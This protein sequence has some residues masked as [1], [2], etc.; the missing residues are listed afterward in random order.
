MK[1]A[2]QTT[3]KIPDYALSYLINDDESG[4]NEEDIQTIDQWINKLEEG[5]TQTIL[6]NVPNNTKLDFILD[7]FPNPDGN[8]ESYFTHTPDFG[9]PCNVID[10]IL[11]ILVEDN[12]EPVFLARMHINS[13][14]G[15]H[16]PYNPLTAQTWNKPQDYNNYYNAY[17]F[18]RNIG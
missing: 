11:T 12:I 3:Y 2:L 6:K 5:L 1:I 13:N 18:Y 10:T 16:N 14:Y 8:N 15:Y 17:Q 9:L 7:P 4:I